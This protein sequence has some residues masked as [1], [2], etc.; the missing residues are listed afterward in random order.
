[1]NKGIIVVGLPES[2]AFCDIG[3]ITKSNGTIRCRATRLDVDD[4]IKPEWCPIKPIPQKKKKYGIDSRRL[5][6][7]KNGW[8][9]AIDKMMGVHDEK[10]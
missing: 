2:C 7:F 4:E 3:S 5:K 10:T 9:A 6:S 1:M 8:N